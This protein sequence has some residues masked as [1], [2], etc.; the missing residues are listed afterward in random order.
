LQVL[1]AVTRHHGVELSEGG[2]LHHYNLSDAPLAP[3]QLMRILRDQ[4]FRTASKRLSWQS[5]TK[6][7]EAYPAIMPLQNGGYV[8]IAGT[9]DGPDGAV[10][11]A[12]L[13]PMRDQEG[14]IYLSARQFAAAGTGEIILTKRVNTRRNNERQFDLSWFL[15]HMWRE[16]SSFG[17]IAVAA[18]ALIALGLVTPLFF[19]IVID[20]VLLHESRTTLMVLGGGVLVAL[21]FEAVLGYLRT[22]LLLH[23]AN[24]LDVQLAGKTFGHLMRLPLHFFDKSA[25][26][27]VAKHMQQS[28]QIR[29]F[30]AGSLFLTLLDA[31]ALVIFLPILFSY[32][33]ILGGVV[34]GFSLLM[35]LAILCVMPGFTRALQR[36]YQTEGERQAML[37]ET[38]HGMRTVKS[39]ALEP[40]QNRRWN[41]STAQAV[42]ARFKV[43]Q[44]GNLVRTLIGLSD[45][46][47]TVAI[48]WVGAEL[49]FGR[50][51]T[52]GELVAI[53]MLAGRVSQP[54][55]QLASLANEFQQTR[56]S[57]KM[58]G[59]IMN[60]RPEREQSGAPLR[61]LI[62]GHITLEQAAYTYPQAQAPALHDLTLEIPAGSRIG[63][64]GKSG[65]GKSTFTRLLQGLYVP[66]SGHVRFDGVDLRE[67][68]LA[69]LRHQ[70]GVVLQESFL[71]TGS[72]RDNIAAARPS[73]S[74][75]EVV[76]AARVAG[77]D[78]FIQ[79]LAQGYD[80]HLE[81]NASNLSGGQKQ[82]IAIARALL[83]QPPILIFDEATSALDPES[84]AIV[85]D[86]LQAITEGRTFI[87]I[88]HRLTTLVNCDRIYVFDQGR[89]IASG[90]HAELLQLS[91]LYQELWR[92]QTR[93]MTDAAPRSLEASV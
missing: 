34:L 20:K 73:A 57:V 11:L 47:M 5:V 63:I 32:S 60:R 14:F 62:S 75:A 35:A 46:F 18:L 9:R 38:I 65:S 36:L 43:G 58:L 21:L 26:G 81:E 50:Q 53:Q 90:K 77:A 13:D 3:A 44:L 93:H 48:V 31:V 84:E 49:V 23:A 37:I 87:A 82:R 45:K 15:W 24:R 28:E 40:R 7:G 72:V 66:D 61:P 55:T 52:I 4:Q 85:Q 69:H 74:F 92:Q 91:P 1:I 6:L 80:T 39:L 51:L 67:I 83:A 19:Q 8:I 78:E 42:M 41:D 89:I 88:S 70:I 17:H 33:A 25:S 22:S 16:R 12:V 2:L 68:D 64:V 30:L 56:L 54:L 79:R 71:F 76:A 29:E 10:Q 27:V 59:E 86:N